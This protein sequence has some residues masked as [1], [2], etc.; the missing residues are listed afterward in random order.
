MLQA[1][2]YLSG[3][4][5]MT[6]QTGNV[7]VCGDTTMWNLLHCF[8]HGIKPPF[9]FVSAS[10]HQST[11]V[12]P[13]AGMKVHQIINEFPNENRFDDYNRSV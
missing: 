11:I 6:K 2:A 8:V 9:C 5:R 1:N 7:S 4:T 12:T 3:T 13:S 10:H